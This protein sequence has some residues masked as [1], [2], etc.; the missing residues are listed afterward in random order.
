MTRK[1]ITSVTLAMVFTVS[2]MTI[3]MSNVYAMPVD[4]TERQQIVENLVDE[5][6]A[7]ANSQF[8]VEKELKI[9]EESLDSELTKINIDSDKIASIQIEMDRLTAYLENS[10]KDLLTI[11]QTVDSV[12]QM[13]PKL[14]KQLETARIILL[15]SQDTI[16]WSGLGTSKTSQA[17]E[18]SIVDE[19][20]ESYRPLIEELIGEDVPLIIKQGAKNPF[21]SCSSRTTDCSDLQGG[22]RITKNLGGGICT[23]GFAVTYDSDEGFLTAGHC[24][25]INADVNQPHAVDPKI[26][27]VTAR[28]WSYLGDIGFINQTSGDTWDDDTIYAGPNSEY[29]G[30]DTNVNP[31]STAIIAMSGASSD[32]ID[33]GVVDSTN[34]T[35]SD[36]TVSASGMYLTTG[37]QALV[38]D[39]GAPV[40]N[41]TFNVKEFY[42]VVSC[43]QSS[44]DNDMA[45]ENWT[46]IAS[47]LP[48]VS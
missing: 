27:E 22:L 28:T 43:F 48:G 25:A 35:C 24:Y 21:T 9:L 42:G 1:Q 45:F 29:T 7:I 32:F 15:T 31:S 19:N 33:W 13:D 18:I 37:T 14:E 26:G 30:I 5:Y 46:T 17:V 36:G 40:F 34:H 2:L 16:P 3:G 8:Q 6:G 39:S 23:L 47:R 11:Q 10:S 38:G 4:D 44:T 20:P 12:L 41:P